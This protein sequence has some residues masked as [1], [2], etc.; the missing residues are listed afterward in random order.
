MEDDDKLVLET[1]CRVS[2]VS[3]EVVDIRQKEVI[4]TN[5]WTSKH[6]G[7]TADEFHD[8]S[9]NLFEKIVH[10]DDRTRQLE[11]YNYLFEHPD[12][13]FKEVTIRVKRKD[14]MYDYLQI[15]LCVLETGP[16]KKPQTVLCTVMDVNEVIKLR[17]N[18]EAQLKKLD[19]I[20]FKNSHDLRGPVATILGLIQLIEHEH[21]DGEHSKEI[22]G[23]LKKAVVKLDD[24]IHEIN[25]QT[26]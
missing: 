5:G 7:Y 19:I 20:S 12:C 21:F 23:C 3:I 6:L 26:Y 13:P 15:R 24:V 14:D 18:L 22:I 1:L 17:Q 8:L 16:D 10:P 2:P 4:C 11:A 25:A 9:R